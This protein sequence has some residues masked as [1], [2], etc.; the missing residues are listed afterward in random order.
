MKMCINL[1]SKMIRC[2]NT[3]SKKENVSFG[4]T[5][6]FRLFLTKEPR[7]QPCCNM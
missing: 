5:K 7:P 4:T 1:G 6:V 2:Y 3:F